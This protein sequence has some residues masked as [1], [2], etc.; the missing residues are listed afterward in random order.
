MSG[1]SAPSPQAAE[2]H[3]LGQ[4]LTR[5]WEVGRR[6]WTCV[7]LLPLVATGLLALDLGWNPVEPR[8]QAGGFTFHLTFAFLASAGALAIALLLMYAVSLHLEEGRLDFVAA[9]LYARNGLQGAYADDLGLPLLRY[10][11]PL[12][13]ALDSP[14]EGLPGLRRIRAI[15]TA[16][17][18]AI[19][20]VA[21]GAA[22]L[23]WWTLPSAASIVLYL[24][25]LGV[26]GLHFQ[27][28][29]GT[30]GV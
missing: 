16:L 21:R 9:Q 27:G 15:A 20:V 22:W 7:T 3:Y 14:F 29:S 5:L 17:A 24:M 11:H 26:F 30:S 25:Y 10:P 1:L 12:R 8:F 18:S 4:L 23:S 2:L 13:V 28:G 19:V 6:A